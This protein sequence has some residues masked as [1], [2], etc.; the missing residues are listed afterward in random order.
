MR[1]AGVGGP[2]VGG[3]DELM[4]GRGGKRMSGPIILQTD[5]ASQAL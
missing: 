5:P 1:E 4:H 3:D 2:V